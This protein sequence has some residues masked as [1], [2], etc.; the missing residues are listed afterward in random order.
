MSNP[1]IAPS[2]QFSNI[3][4]LERARI[5]EFVEA[6]CANDPLARRVRDGMIFP[7]IDNDG[8]E[9]FKRAVEIQRPPRRPEIFAQVARDAAAAYVHNERVEQSRFRPKAIGAAA[10]DPRIAQARA[11]R[12]ESVLA[13][14]GIRLRKSGAELVGACPRCG[15]DDRFGVN[16][17]KGLFNC[18]QCGARGDTIALVEFLDNVNFLAA[19]EILVGPKPNGE[20]RAESNFRQVLVATFDYVDE[21]GALL[22]QSQRFQFKR[23]DG[24]FVLET[25]GKKKKHFR[26]RRP[27][28]NGGWINSVTTKD[29][30]G[31]AVWAVRNVPYRLPELIEAVANNYFIMILEG[32]A[33]VDLARSWNIP[34]TCCVGG[35][36]KWTDAHSEFFRDADAVIL[37]DKDVAGG[38]H[39]NNVGSSLAEVN[40]SVRV[41]NLPGLPEKGDIIDWVKAAGTPEK[42]HEL[43]EREAKPWEPGKGDEA[44]PRANGQ[45]QAPVI[46]AHSVKGGEFV[47]SYIPMSYAIEGVLPCGFIYGLTGRR[48][49]GKTAWLIAA[50]AASVKGEGEKILGFPV[51]KGRV[52]YVAKENPEDLK[53]KLAVNCYFHGIDGDTLDA[54]L[55]V[56]DG[57]ADSPE[58]ICE[59]LR[60]DA[61]ANGGFSL[62][63]YD[64]F[65][66]GFSAAS[67]EEFNNNAAVLAFAV[68]LRPLTDIIGKPAEIV[69]FHPTKNASEDELVPYG[70]GSIVNEI[71]GNLTLWKS[72]CSQIKLFQ[73]R[74]RGPEF[75]PC[76]Y[77]I[78][79]LSSPDIVDDKGRQILLPI[80]RP[81]TALDV[82]ERAIAL[83]NTKLALL[84]AMLAA[85]NAPQRE[86][87]TAIGVSVSTVNANLKA[88][89]REKLIKKVLGDFVLTKSGEMLA[90]SKD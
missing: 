87:A 20:G 60:I 38:R 51:R 48:S 76:Y 71:D 66:A 30:D 55:L 15:G 29:K 39:V 36:K 5:D 79:K 81:T 7:I 1:N 13:G 74:V 35:S 14:R 61:Q 22:F 50:T 42:L 44:E 16:K 28:G 58:Q 24:S 68:R 45:E 64:T 75:E 11:V 32:E 65:Q 43:I 52:A 31:N 19:V 82:A 12:I 25:D 41:L 54:R 85:P 77:R 2:S 63:L 33:K 9:A 6:L 40:C 88:L 89:E 10:T 47:R 49:H 37:P 4:N 26:L 84:R 86:L 23:P 21:S 67:A 90:T 73:N 59:A 83:K 53:M 56:L 70:G 18:R 72:E 8:F 17:E 62:V 69:A 34:A 27:D 80:M 3:V 46:P 78:E 57:R